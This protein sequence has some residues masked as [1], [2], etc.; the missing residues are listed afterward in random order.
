MDIMD[1]QLYSNKVITAFSFTF[2][3]YCMV[4]GRFANVREEEVDEAAMA[5]VAERIHGFS[6]PAAIVVM[7][8]RKL[9]LRCKFSNEYQPIM[10]CD[11][12]FWFSVIYF[13]A[14]LNN[15]RW[16]RNLKAI[17]LA[18]DVRDTAVSMQDEFPK[19]LQM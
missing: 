10:K 2:Y 16:P 15:F 6:A 19:V 9:E 3:F 7:K 18:S 4:P 13:L 8:K 14:A 5:V 17:H 1:F 12:W 11:W